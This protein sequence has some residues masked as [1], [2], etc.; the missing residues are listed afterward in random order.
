MDSLLAATAMEHDLVLITRNL[1]DVADLPVEA[2][3]PWEQAEE[4]PA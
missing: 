3:N 4:P 2:F 1:K